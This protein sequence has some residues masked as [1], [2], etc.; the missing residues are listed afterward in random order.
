ME[1]GAHINAEGE[2][3]DETGSSHMCESPTVAGE[4]QEDRSDHDDAVAQKQVRAGMT[5]PHSDRTNG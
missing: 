4:T 3:R 1:R 2:G 5:P